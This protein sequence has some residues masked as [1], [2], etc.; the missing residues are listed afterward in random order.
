MY[1]SSSSQVNSCD[2]QQLYFIYKRPAP[3][4][5]KPA[6]DQRDLHTQKENNLLTKVIEGTGVIHCN[7][8]GTYAQF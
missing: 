1:I 4:D 5:I 8:L 7:E 2:V 6:T 3:I